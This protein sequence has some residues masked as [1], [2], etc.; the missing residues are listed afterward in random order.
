MDKNL[1]PLI[2]MTGFMIVLFGTQIWTARKK[3]A[4]QKAML[5]NLKVGDK[6]VTIGGIT[7][8]IAAVLTDTVEIKIDKTARMTILK[9]AVSRV[10]E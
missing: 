3:S 5:D 8:T 7:G 10:T 2:L 1:Q 6:I 4:K 9:T